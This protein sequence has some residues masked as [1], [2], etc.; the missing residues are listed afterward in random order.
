MRITWVPT[1]LL[2]HIM[3]PNSFPK[4]L[5]AFT[6][7]STNIRG[8]CVKEKAKSRRKLEAIKELDT[9]ISILID[10][11]VDKQGLDK[12]Y[13]D[14]RPILCKYNVISNY[15]AKRGILVLIKKQ[16]G[17]TL[18]NVLDHDDKNILVI[19]VMTSANVTIDIA[20]I[21]GPSDKDDPSF[22]QEV[23]NTLERRQSC[24][25]S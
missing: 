16:T 8:L 22:F 9:D 15:A 25:T 23:Y 3:Y 7:S 24:H 11:H 2:I 10:S 1:I 12:L 4:T 18:G 17:I 20:A 13:K 5:S 6:I 14:H 21:Y 19:S